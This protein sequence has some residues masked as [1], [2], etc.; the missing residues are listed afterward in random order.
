MF[1]MQGTTTAPKRT[2]CLRSSIK[3]S[4]KK[5]IQPQRIRIKPRYAE[6]TGRAKPGRDNSRNT[7]CRSTIALYMRI[8]KHLHNSL[9]VRR[10]QSRVS[11][12]LYLA[13]SSGCY[14]GRY[15]RDAVLSALAPATAARPGSHPDCPACYLLDREYKFVWACRP[16]PD[17]LS[18]LVPLDP[19]ADLS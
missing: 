13:L 14:A 4:S 5:Y 3:R 17:S 8:S 15:S 6:S 11:V 10:V 9:N 19:P 16:A 2:G 7:I 12:P 18:V 1:R